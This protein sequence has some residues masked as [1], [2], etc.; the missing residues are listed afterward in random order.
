MGP[1][2]RIK[3]ANIIAVLLVISCFNVSQ[4]YHKHFLVN[5]RWVRIPFNALNKRLLSV[6]IANP[7]K[8]YIDNYNFP[9]VYLK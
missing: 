6:F 5:N 8:A 4:E 2:M 1:Y 9:L 3:L 7:S